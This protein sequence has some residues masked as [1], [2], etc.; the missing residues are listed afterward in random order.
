MSGTTR[1]K[2]FPSLPFFR[3]RGKD[4]IDINDL[5]V[6]LALYVVE[7]KLETIAKI[8][9]IENR[10]LRCGWALGV[11]LPIRRNGEVSHHYWST[12]ISTGKN[13]YLIFFDLCPNLFD[14]FRGFC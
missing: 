3:D 6:D 4:L 8:L 11:F 5:K 10:I 13:L 2:N 7:V 1:R 9:G 14:S 12:P